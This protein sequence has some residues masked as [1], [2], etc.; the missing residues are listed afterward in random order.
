MSDYL[1][2]LW[3]FN[4][5]IAVFLA[6]PTVWAAV[7]N[8]GLIAHYQFDNNVNDSSGHNN[9]G[10]NDG[11]SS[12]TTDLF[13]KSYRAL[14]L[15]GETH[16]DVITVN[17]IDDL[18]FTEALTVV[19]WV[20]I[21]K[22]GVLI[23]Q[24]GF[25]PEQGRSFYFHITNGRLKMSV[26]GGSGSQGVDVVSHNAIPQDG[27]WHHLAGVFDHGQITLY[28]DGHQQGTNSG[29]FTG[30]ADS[31]DRISIGHIYSYCDD[32]SEG[33]ANHEEYAFAGAMDDLRLYKRALSEKE[34]EA[35]VALEKWLIAHYEFDNDLSDSSGHENHGTNEGLSSFTTDM[36]E[37]ANSAIQFNGETHQDVISVDDINELYPTNELT[38][39]VWVKIDKTGVIVRQGGFCPENGHSFDFQITKDGHLMMSVFGGSGSNGVEVVSDKGI[40]PDGNWHHLA[41]VFSRGQITLYIDGHQQGNDSGNFEG[42]ADSI[43]RIS[44]GHIYSYCDD[45]SEGYANNEEY[46]FAGAIDDMRF[47]N[48][49]L[50]EYD[51]EAICCKPQASFSCEEIDNTDYSEQAKR[52]L[53]DCDASHSSVYGGYLTEYHWTISKPDGSSDT[54]NGA[55]Q[56]FEFDIDKATYRIKLT[57]TDNSGRT[58]QPKQGEIKIRSPSPVA[59]FTAT[60]DKGSVPLTVT[61]DATTSYDPDGTIVKYDWIT[62]T[63]IEPG[64]KSSVTLD[65]P[66]THNITLTVTDNEGE[67]GSVA[68]KV[69]VCQA[70]MTVTDEEGNEIKDTASLVA[71]VILKLEASDSTKYQW[72]TE[73]EQSDT[74]LTDHLEKNATLIFA[75]YGRCTVKLSITDKDDCKADTDQVFEIKA[76]PIA[77]IN[78][79]E[80]LPFSCVREDKLPLKL[81][82]DA[83][84]YS[85]YLSDYSYDP[86]GNI[87]QYEWK[88]CPGDKTDCA[89]PELQI[90][91][92]QTAEIPVE[93]I[94]LY[95][96]MLKVTDDDGLTSDETLRKIELE[97]FPVK[98]CPP[99]PVALVKPTFAKGPPLIVELDGSQSYDLYGEYGDEIAGYEWLSYP[100]SQQIA[101]GKKA[102]FTNKES[103]ENFIILKV[104]DKQGATKTS[105]PMKVIVNHPPIADFTFTSQPA[106]KTESGQFTVKVDGSASSDSD[107]NITRYQWNSSDGQ[108][109]EDK[110]AKFTYNKPNKYAI[111]LTVTDNHNV[112]ATAPEKIVH[113]RPIADFITKNIII[114]PEADG[115]FLLNLD[116]NASYDPDGGTIERYDGI[117]IYPNG[118]RVPFNEEFQYSAT[119]HYIDECGDYQMILTVTD[120]EGTQSDPITQPIKINCQPEAQFEVFQPTFD[121]QFTI[122]LDGK[123]SSDTDGEIVKYQWE[124][125][126]TEENPG[127]CKTVPNQ[128]VVPVEFERCGEYYAVTL[129]VT[130]DLGAAT[131]SPVKTIKINCLPKPV[132]TPHF[133]FGHLPVGLTLDASDSCDP[134]GEITDYQWTVKGCDQDRSLWAHKQS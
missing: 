12:F 94:G 25:C 51:I 38:V 9:H 129:T 87:S 26:F 120:D 70:N 13:G 134:D 18:Y 17:D 34:I 77:I 95:T 61:L 126:P 8:D 97:N 78:K 85:P 21:D 19:A 57:V 111:T 103:G 131:K 28:I 5:A 48:R 125:C 69:T 47:Y 49:A 83:G 37:K 39:A 55:K 52:W 75:S 14:Q 3:R 35:I 64:K 81:S 46:A 56:T 58:S 65:K 104:T 113:F 101:E 128:Q 100:D 110:T 29:N 43:D 2:R 93:K 73:C 71:P 11:F 90:G 108:T 50:S 122:I 40:P 96:V 16:Q 27:Q 86:D 130:D 119:N 116:A 127:Q 72:T 117:V 118:T 114:R 102:S 44:I 89:K 84:E 132:F 82:L 62:T 7:S 54:F 23:Q 112:T 133:L 68:K 106:E 124:V 59:Q 32:A 15:N 45:A 66:M 74:T 4:L 115:K 53:V 91:V 92:G 31:L 20:K 6:M 33:Y 36:F 107:G 60:P 109:A 80:V 67:T 79:T 42:M 88:V 98:N 30:M 41:G 76:K 121:A 10:S 1:M 22:D 99:V 24:G 63:T 105:E 123:D